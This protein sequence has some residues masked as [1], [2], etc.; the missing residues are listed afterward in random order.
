MFLPYQVHRIL[1]NLF[2]FFFFEQKE[3]LQG[4]LYSGQIGI[5]YVTV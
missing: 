4:E 1:S 3:I 5:S 2:L